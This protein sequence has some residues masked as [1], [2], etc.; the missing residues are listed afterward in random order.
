MILN[1]NFLQL[2]L[3]LLYII[4]LIINAKQIQDPVAKHDASMCGVY[5]CPGLPDLATKYLQ[6][7][8]IQEFGHFLNDERDLSKAS[9]EEKNNLMMETLNENSENQNNECTKLVLIFLAIGSGLI[10]SMFGYY[11]GIWEQKQNKKVIFVNDDL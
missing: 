1:K 8:C 6:S 5:L 3:F 9:H 7:G 11:I 4:F 10:S 2:K